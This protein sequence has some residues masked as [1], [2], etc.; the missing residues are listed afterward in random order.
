MVF[1]LLF[2][3]ISLHYKKTIMAKMKGNWAASCGSDD[4]SSQW[5]LCKKATAAVKYSKVPVLLLPPDLLIKS[6]E[7][8]E[9]YLMMHLNM[10]SFQ[11]TGSHWVET[12]RISDW[13][14]SKYQQK[15]EIAH[16]PQAS[17]CTAAFMFDITCLVLW[18]GFSHV[19][20]WC[21]QGSDWHLCCE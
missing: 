15:Y 13:M 4:H 11:W 6:A 3:A 7:I 8:T 17:V 14:L 5:E 18:W 2:S 1:S 19:V 16:N 12:G 10:L 20:S 21:H 9:W